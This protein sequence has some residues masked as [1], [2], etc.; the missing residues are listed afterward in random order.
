MKTQELL[1]TNGSDTQKVDIMEHVRPR[2]A[3]RAGR[4]PILREIIT[5][6]NYHP[7]FAKAQW[8]PLNAIE[9]EAG[10]FSA[11]SLFN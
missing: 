7:S 10:S 8:I 5:E 4:I 11:T 9:I 3:S 2:K 1:E 6:Y